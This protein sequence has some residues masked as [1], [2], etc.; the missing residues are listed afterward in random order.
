[1]YFNTTFATKVNKIRRYKNLFVQTESI[2]IMTKCCEILSSLERV[3]SRYTI[4]HID[5]YCEE[6]RIVHEWFKQ[7]PIGAHLR[8]D[9]D[10]FWLSSTPPLI[11][12]KASVIDTRAG[13]FVK[14]DVD[15]TKRQT[16]ERRVKV[17]TNNNDIFQLI[18]SQIIIK[19]LQIAGVVLSFAT[20]AVFYATY[21]PLGG[22]VGS[23][24]DK[25]V[26]TF[27]GVATKKFVK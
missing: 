27:G 15:E 19:A 2:K 4:K 20:Q 26:T 17:R 10:C 22:A 24:V 3:K 11:E 8:T 6:Q 25:A 14:E 9:D 12:W 13:D 23:V 16:R 5:D 21:V 1:M 18:F 7:A